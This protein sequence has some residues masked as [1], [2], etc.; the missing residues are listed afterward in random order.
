M[1]GVIRPGCDIP[2]PQHRT[3]RAAAAGAGSGQ[4]GRSATMKSRREA[5]GPE[6]EALAEGKGW[7][8]P[9]NKGSNAL[10]VVDGELNVHVILV[11]QENILGLSVAF[12]SKGS[13]N[14]CLHNSSSPRLAQL[15][16]LLG[17][18]TPPPSYLQR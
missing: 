15:Q 16:M 2:G 9:G 12:Q 8:N 7:G 11:L 10:S 3:H 13:L 18:T 4:A 6:E 14:L 1:R 17:I 5:A